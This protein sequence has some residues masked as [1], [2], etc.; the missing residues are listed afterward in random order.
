MKSGYVAVKKNKK[1]ALEFSFA[2]IF[3]IIAGMFVLFLAIYGVAKFANIEKT[4]QNAQTATDIGV[5]TNPLE[6]SFESMKRIL[7]T[8][9]VETRIYTSCDSGGGYFGKQI[10]NTSQKVYNQWTE[11]EESVNAGVENKYIF[12]EDPAEGRR[13]YAFSAPFE[14][15]FKITDLIYLT[16][17][18]DKYCFVNAPASVEE[19][20]NLIKGSEGGSK[21]ENLF[22]GDDDNPCPEGSMHV[23][24]RNR[25]SSCDVFVSTTSNPPFVEKDQGKMYYEGSALMYAAIFSEKT[26]YECQ[27]KRIMARA[28]ELYTVYLNKSR[29]ISQK[30]GCPQELDSDLLIFNTAIDNFRSSSDI[31]YIY[32]ASQDLERQNKLADCRLW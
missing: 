6:S 3:A 7:I 28:G 4:S 16:S 10:I 30:V 2:W 19:D 21:N 14:M 31:G 24:F 5:L 22:I 18:D 29:F 25:I 1:G 23:C 20:I 11:S 17:T 12:G 15:P 27:L 26:E 8:M 9:P 32:S 13:F